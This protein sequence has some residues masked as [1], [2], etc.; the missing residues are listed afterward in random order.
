MVTAYQRK[1]QIIQ[2]LD[3]L[4]EDRLEEVIDFVEFLH[5]KHTSPQPAY[6]P[7]ALGGLWLGISA[8]AEDIAEVRHEIWGAFGDREL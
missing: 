5:T 8:D 2:L 7:I 3:T 6:V 4:P 1:Q